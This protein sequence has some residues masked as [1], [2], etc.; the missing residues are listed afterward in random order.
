MPKRA[1]A[2]FT[3]QQCVLLIDDGSEQLLGLAHRPAVEVFVVSSNPAL[4]VLVDLL[5]LTLVCTGFRMQLELHHLQSNLRRL[6][7]IHL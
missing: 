1:N 5:D 4:D 3:H 2:H 7:E 6:H